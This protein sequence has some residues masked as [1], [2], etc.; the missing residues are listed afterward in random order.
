MKL[1][2]N[3]TKENYKLLKEVADY[4]NIK[5]EQVIEDY[6]LLNKKIPDFKIARED[7]YFITIL[8]NIISELELLK[9]ETYKSKE[10]IKSKKEQYK[11]I[12]RYLDASQLILDIINNKYKDCTK[13]NLNK[14]KQK[15]L[16][17][18]FHMITQLHEKVASNHWKL[19][20]FLQLLAEN[21]E[22]IKSINIK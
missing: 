20:E 9:N 19:V 2:I 22:E 15:D 14:N 21:F 5:V 3:I 17:V 16:E 4:Q 11:L 18:Y 7:K 12:H 8:L 10:K 1:E 13:N 6:F